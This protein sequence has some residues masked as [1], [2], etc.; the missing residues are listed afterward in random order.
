MFG[1]ERM[2]DDEIIN[3]AEEIKKQRSCEHKNFTIYGYNMVDEATCIDCGYT[4]KIY[5]FYN[6]LIERLLKLEKRLE[7]KLKK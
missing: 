6:K 3:K 5:R 7:K 2:S 4:D 1:K